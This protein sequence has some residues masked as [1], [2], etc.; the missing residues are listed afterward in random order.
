MSGPPKEKR[1]QAIEQGAQSKGDMPIIA[2][3]SRE[4]QALEL[5]REAR[6]SRLRVRA[7]RSD[8]AFARL[9]QLAGETFVVGKWGRFIEMPSLHAAERWFDAIGAE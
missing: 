2:L 9:D 5:D 8:C 6:I 3:G 4:L 1:P 7:A